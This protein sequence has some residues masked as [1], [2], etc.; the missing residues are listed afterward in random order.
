MKPTG[1]VAAGLQV[2]RCALS[3]GFERVQVAIGWSFCAGKNINIDNTLGHFSGPNDAGQH[4]SMNRLITPA[5][6][7]LE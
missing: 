6:K 3:Q 7:I 1:H 5:T 4:G 2:P